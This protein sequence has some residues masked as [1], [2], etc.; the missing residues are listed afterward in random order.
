[1]K[2]GYSIQRSR[3]KL[4]GP[5]RD[6]KKVKNVGHTR[7]ISESTCPKSAL[8]Y[9]CGEMEIPVVSILCGGNAVYLV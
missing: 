6:M 9:R 3:K 5:I 4:Y 8:N 1:M 7:V 2:C